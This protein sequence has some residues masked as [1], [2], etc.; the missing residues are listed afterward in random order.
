MV[1]KGKI[2]QESVVL[3]FR[4]SALEC[5]FKVFSSTG[6]DDC[7]LSGKRVK[8]KCGSES[9]VDPFQGHV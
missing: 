4:V 1:T 5:F 8:R 2:D 9:V 7:S 6:A 3:S